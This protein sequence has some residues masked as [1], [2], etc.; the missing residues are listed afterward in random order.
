M[1]TSQSGAYT[2]I[3]VSRDEDVFLREAISSALSQTRGPSELFVV[4]NPGSRSD[5]Y[6]AH[7]ARSFGRPV[8]IL[9]ASDAGLIAGLNAG[10]ESTSTEF[11]A[12]LDSD[13]L[14][15][16]HKQ[17][18]QLKTLLA[19]PNLDASTSL[20][21]NFRDAP[22]GTREHVL[23][24]PGIMFTNTTFRTSTFAR[25]GKID[26]SATH[27]TWLAR[28][29][30]QARERGIRMSRIESVGVLRRI[31]SE[32]SWVTESAKAHQELRNELRSILAQKRANQRHP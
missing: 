25:F 14:W 18:V 22:D 4:L 20:V 11:V 10:I 5:S 2:A 8:R 19:D 17:E 6:A 29:W 32:N 13:D 21:T 9:E 30:S 31:H 24:A 28:W 26:V 15:E 23:T 3:I 12:F 27:Y 7:V 1:V 16:S